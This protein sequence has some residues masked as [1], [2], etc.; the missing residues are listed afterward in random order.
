MKSASFIYYIKIV[1]HPIHGYTMLLLKSK[2]NHNTHV[3]IQRILKKTYKLFKEL[4]EE[5]NGLSRIDKQLSKIII[6]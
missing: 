3:L 4:K 2:L 1:L 6:I 5:H